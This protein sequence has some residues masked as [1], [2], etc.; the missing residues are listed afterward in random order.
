M[1]IESLKQRFPEKFL[2]QEKIFDRIKKGGRLFVGT[3]CGEPQHLVAALVDF[4]ESHPM[5]V[6]EA[7][8]LHVWTLG[9]A[10]YTDSKFK[11]NFR[12]N[13]F[14]IG[15]SAR[16]AINTGAADYTPMFLSQV[17][18]LFARGLIPV[19]VALIQTS[20]PDDEGRLS[21]G[22]SVDITKAA[23][24]N[25]SMVICQANSYM[26]Y[27]RGDTLIDIESV[28]FVVSYDEP[29]LEYRTAVADELV[30]NI[31][32]HVARIIKDG[33]TIQV[34]YGSIPNAI[35][36]NLEGKKHIG[37]H[38]EL[39]SDGIVDLMK[40]G[41]VD[42]SRK[43]IDRGKTVATFCM[44]KR[45]TYQYI[46]D[47]PAIEFRPIDYTNDP[48]V[49]ARNDNMTAIN[50]A[51]AIDLTGQAT[52]ESIGSM[53]YSGIGGQ[54]D[55]MRGAV[56]ARQGKT[57]LAM[58]S[59][60][61]EGKNSRIVPYLHQGSKVTLTSGDIHY[62][63]TEYGIAYLHGKNVR[64]RAMELISIAHPDFR[65]WLI[66]EA[67]KHRLIYADQLFVAGK[68]GEYPSDL[69][70]Y[71]TTEDGMEILLRPVK[72]SDEPLLK[73]FFYALSDESNYRRFFTMRQY[74][75]HEVLQ[76][77]VAIDYTKQMVILAVVREDEREQVV[78]VGQYA[79]LGE[80]HT[81]EVAVAVRDEY[82]QKGVGTELL[83][84]LALIAKREGLHGFSADYFAHNEPINHLVAKS[85]L[86]LSKQ[87]SSGV[88]HVE[89]PF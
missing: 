33:D 80:T 68:E 53:F 63:V 20:L 36:A 41:V 15:D 5:S 12:Y 74:M 78:G 3:G 86:K 71:R 60:A 30:Q 29:L 26:P 77:F 84:Y 38:T 18:D 72:I 48:L 45:S 81:A 9:V 6:I 2:P 47:N 23:S 14:F 49:I 35:L 79:V 24:D 22:I 88:C 7:E 32:N 70:R 42:N 39:L 4:V 8:V 83:A 19:D 58:E 13:T 64:E 43:S 28:D 67:K 65:P 73:D 56:L 40:K 66:E 85:G 46:H 1:D 25:A 17:P 87:I 69:E 27:V 76:K 55:F 44:G 57:I 51:L 89:I 50:S 11:K 75:P 34:G 82:Q 21:L 10:P 62:V 59:T 61:N 37:I 16:D 31:G 54:A 52:A